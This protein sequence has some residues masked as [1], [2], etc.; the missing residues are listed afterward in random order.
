MFGKNKKASRLSLPRLS[1]HLLPLAR[2]LDGVA[3]EFNNTLR[4]D[5][6]KRPPFF[7]G[8]AFSQAIQ[9]RQRVVVIRLRLFDQRI[10]HTK[11][12]VVVGLESS[13]RNRT[14]TASVIIFTIG[15]F[16]NSKKITV[17]V[18]TRCLHIARRAGTTN[19]RE[20]NG[21]LRRKRLLIVYCSSHEQHQINATPTTGV[22]KHSSLTSDEVQACNP[23]DGA[24][25]SSPPVKTSAQA[26]LKA[27]RRASSSSRRDRPRAEGPPGRCAE[28]A[29]K[30][31]QDGRADPKK[32]P[33]PCSPPSARSR[34]NTKQQALR[35][36]FISLQ[37]QVHYHSA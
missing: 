34:L 23:L 14:I 24:Q 29:W 5:L 15:T 18:K 6:P 2:L 1:P 27:W 13:G 33:S 25:A 26:A 31:L 22:Q 28:K 21:T 11:T 3:E 10:P 19:T 20:K 35:R 32:G 17:P 4:A 9:Q 16:S 7:R 8:G 30:I 36:R 12:S 37:A